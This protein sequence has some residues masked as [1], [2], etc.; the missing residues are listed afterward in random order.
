MERLRELTSRNKTNQLTW[1]E[2][3]RIRELKELDIEVCDYGHVN[4]LNLGWE[5]W[6]KWYCNKHE[7]E[8]ILCPNLCLPV[9]KN[10]GCELLRKRS[11][12]TEEPVKP[13]RPY[14]LT[15]CYLCFKELKGAG[16]HGV[17][18]NRNNPNF[19]GISSSYK[20]LCLKC[21]G[22]EFYNRL[23]SGKKK[24]W[25]KYLKRGYV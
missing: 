18:K 5:P 7:K 16:K 19:W 10:I 15:N 8:H 1:E 24:T 13:N 11:K 12:R 14:Y 3:Q 9:S 25:R 2:Y 6:G 21:M 4:I 22:K 20:I 17:V 23:S